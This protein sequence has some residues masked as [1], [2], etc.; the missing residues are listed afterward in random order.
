MK[1]KYYVVIRGPEGEQELD[2]AGLSEERRKEIVNAL[3]TKMLEHLNYIPEK[4]A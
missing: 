4:T 1:I 3:N 2:L